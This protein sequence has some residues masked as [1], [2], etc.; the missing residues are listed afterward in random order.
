[1]RFHRVLR[2]LAFLV[3][4]VAF[5]AAIGFAVM[6]LWNALIPQLFAGPAVRFWQA[7]GLLVLS[8]LLVGGFRGAGRHGW[9]HR[10]WHR[11]WERMSPEERARFRDGFTRWK[12]MTPEERSEFRRGFGGCRGA[13]PQAATQPKE[14]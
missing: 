13:M 10:A 2:G 6:L 5:V 3:L 12:H 9:R 4:G 8:R 7:V 1:V 14:T 11:R